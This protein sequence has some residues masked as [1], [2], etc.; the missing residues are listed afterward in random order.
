MNK[1]R[2]FAGP[3]MIALTIINL[4]IFLFGFFML[5]PGLYTSITAIIAD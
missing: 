3:K 2:L 5:G 4:L 1:G